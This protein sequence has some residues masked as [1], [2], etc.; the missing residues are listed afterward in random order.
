MLLEGFCEEAGILEGLVPA[1]AEV[2][3]SDVKIVSRVMVRVGTN[4]AC[5]VCR[6]ADEEDTSFVPCFELWPIV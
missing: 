4:W 2:L 3:H 5:R 6:V 1:L